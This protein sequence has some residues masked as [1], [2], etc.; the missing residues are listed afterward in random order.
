[1]TDPRTLKT[2]AEKAGEYAELTTGGT[3]KDPMFHRF[4]EAI[5]KGGHVLDLG[6]GPGHY[7]ALMAQSELQ[8][9]ATDAVPEMVALAAEQPGVTAHCAT[10]DDIEGTDLYDGIWANFSL[11]HAPRAD[12]PRHLAALKLALKSDGL[13]HIGLKTG[14]GSKRDTINRLYTYYTY[15]EL[16]NMLTE[17]GFTVIHHTTGTD[18]G[19]DGVPADWVAVHARG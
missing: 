4:V 15:P 7:A 2:Y 6:C 13:F 3:V 9:T 1:M 8:V 17:T 11:L 12:M 19:L 18:K 14:T 16:E 10:F 5:P